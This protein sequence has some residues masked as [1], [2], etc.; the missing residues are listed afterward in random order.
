VDL[1]TLGDRPGPRIE[2]V[3][4]TFPSAV[5]YDALDDA[6]RF[7]APDAADLHVHAQA[8]VSGGGFA[9]VRIS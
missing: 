6:L 1:S 8:F 5:P 7:R 4:E 3:V 9:G 2:I